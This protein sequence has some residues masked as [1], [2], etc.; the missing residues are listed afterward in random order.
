M[1]IRLPF[2]RVNAPRADSRQ[3]GLQSTIFDQ[4][5]RATKLELYNDSVKYSDFSVNTLGLGIAV[6]GSF[7][8]II[9]NA[10]GGAIR[11]SGGTILDLGVSGSQFRHIW[12]DGNVNAATGVIT[13]DDI[14][15]NT[16]M[17]VANRLIISDSVA[18]PVANGQFTRNG[19]DVKVF[20]GGFL[21]NL[22]DIAA[23]GATTGWNDDGTVVR[24]T[25]TTDTVGI[26]TAS[27]DSRV[28]IMDS[29]ASAGPANGA[30]PLTLER[31]GNAL[32]QFL[33]PNTN[34]AGFYFG[35]PQSVS[36]G[37]FYYD[38]SANEFIFA[39]NGSNRL[40]LTSAGYLEPVTNNTYR[41]GSSSLSFAELWSY[42]LRLVDIAGNPNANGQLVF[43][44]NHIEVFS[45]SVVR[46]LSDISARAYHD[47]T[48]SINDNTTTDIALNNEEYD[49]DTIHSNVTNNH[50]L[51][52]TRA[53]KY[54]VMGRIRWS[55]SDTGT[56]QL[57]LNVNGV[58]VDQDII[59]AIGPVSA[60]TLSQH[61]FA[62]VQLAATDYVSM[63]CLQTSGGALTLGSG[64]DDCTLQM[65]LV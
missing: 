30:S 43:N 13:G 12:L 47:T 33:T 36:V 65:A 64:T 3:G 31:N 60:Q 22:S 18:N 53:G 42:T 54:I 63:S 2:D 7:K 46:V 37:Q 8:N 49:T 57:F 27:P 17:T 23:P 28:H 40:K 10:D 50:R 48:Q 35:D 9:I 16:D 59:G 38:H 6:Y 56:R 26:G 51:T 21:R 62:I 24:L 4:L 5:L 29:D 44:G 34:L 20:S 41:I 61:V 39:T 11:P 15:A 25:T 55:V 14:F 19:T 52:A 45:N 32:A 58:T 1:P